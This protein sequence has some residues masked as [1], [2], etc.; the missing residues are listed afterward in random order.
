MVRVM[1]EA[2]EEDLDT[3]WSI[4]PA[5]TG[6][7]EEN[8]KQ[9]PKPQPPDLAYVWG[10]QAPRALAEGLDSAFFPAVFLNPCSVFPDS[11]VTIFGDIS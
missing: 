1:A 6:K 3:P 9:Y 5:P 8:A 7:E 4:P 11:V 10:G 2:P